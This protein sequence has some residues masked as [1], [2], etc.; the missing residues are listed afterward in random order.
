[1]GDKGQKSNNVRAPQSPAVEALVR[2]RDRA[3]SDATRSRVLILIATAAA[4]MLEIVTATPPS[5]D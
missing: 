4:I 2:T 3:Q 1:M 5:I